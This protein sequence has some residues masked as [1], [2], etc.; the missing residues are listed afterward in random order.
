MGQLVEAWTCASGSG[1]G[2]PDFP[3]LGVE[4]KTLPVSGRGRPR[5]STWVTAASTGAE[6][7]GSWEQ[8]P[9]YQKLRRVLWVPLRVERGERSAGARVFGAPFL[10]SPSPAQDATL[11]EDWRELSEL[12]RLGDDGMFDAR[13]GT[14]LQLRPKARDSRVS[15]WLLDQRGEW[16][17]AN[18]RGFYLRASFT[19]EILAAEFGP[20]PPQ[21]VAAGQG[22]RR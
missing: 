16:V 11:R 5:E 20:Q 4:L 10:W 9:A 12:L 18:P 2:V 13:R 19:A 1:H 8:S 6:V 17:P 7:A 3:A 15:R 21:A 22:G 14:A